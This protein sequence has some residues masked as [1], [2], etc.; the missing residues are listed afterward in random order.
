MITNIY[1]KVLQLFI[2]NNA[3]MSTPL[4]SVDGNTYN[5]S[6]IYN[7]TSSINSLNLK[8]LMTKFNKTS[9]YS[10]NSYIYFGDSNE[11]ESKED[12]M[13]KGSILNSCI[14]LVYKLTT[15]REEDKVKLTTVYTI[16]NISDSTITIREVAII[17]P[18]Y[19]GNVNSY[20]FMFDRTVL[21]EPLT[22]ASGQ[23]GEIT[24]TIENTL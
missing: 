23:V 6:S 18:V 20:K 15:I 16:K 22:L 21:D 14:D 9:T 7:N 12:Y 4:K 10:D 8:Y 13:L 24:Y 19:Y 2:T 5:Y 1:K 3:G 11:P 17:T